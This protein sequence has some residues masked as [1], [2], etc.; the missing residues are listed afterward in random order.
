MGEDSDLFGLEAQ[1]EVAT[2]PVVRT[3]LLIRLA[4]AWSAR[5]VPRALELAQQAIAE[6]RAAG[7]TSGEA[8]AYFEL[9]WAHH[10][11][12]NQAQALDNFQKALLLYQELRDPKG[13]A[14]SLRGLGIVHDSLGNY[15]KAME[16]F[17]E[18]YRLHQS[19]GD[20]SGQASTLNSI[21]I[22][23]SK[24][25]QLEEGLA[26]YRQ[27][28]AL[29]RQLGERR[30]IYMTLS[31][32]G[33]A[34]KNLGRFD[35]AEAV[36]REAL[37]QIGALEHLSRGSVLNNLALVYEHQGRAEEAER[38]HWQSLEHFR[39]GKQ[40][41]GEVEARLCLGRLYLRLGRLEEALILLQEALA[42]AQH[43][44]Q[45]PKQSEAQQALAEVY[46]QRGSLAQ[47]LE[48]LEAAQRL[49]RQVFN[50]NTDRRL[51]NLQISFQVEQVRREAELERRKNAELAQAYAELKE[52]HE[53]LREAD[54]QKTLL[55][56]ELER[57]S[58]EDALT[59]LYNRRY[60]DGRLAEEFHRARRYQHPLSL[61]I[62]DVDDFKQ[63]N[64][65]FSHAVGDVVL[66]TVARLLRQACRET[67]LVARYGGEEFVLLFLEASQEQARNV[68]EKIRLIVAEYPWH[69]LH[70]GLRVTL[71]IGLSSDLSL[72]SP[73]HLLAEAD[74]NLYQAKRLGKNRVV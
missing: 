39:L 42:L 23:C 25:G 14:D 10:N 35:E 67:D 27:S 8:S 50:E 73:A 69:T 11:L 34:L 15:E 2:D 41:T 1:L 65:R 7:Y 64:D 57:L 71:S 9:A 29:A 74:R 40:A 5:D 68:C 55:L 58:L 72:E 63:I 54:R 20:L 26:Y 12:G 47:A 56:Q 62:A 3:E 4:S 33:I 16:Y 38:L 60:L 24:N 22:I 66:R 46:K 61:A 31:N 17:V 36:L 19:Q 49:E 37:E 30:L 18:N 28:C 70:P 51:K 48:H 44:A 59:G 52:L 6:A 45:K 43:T 32:M 21:G 13:T 53:A